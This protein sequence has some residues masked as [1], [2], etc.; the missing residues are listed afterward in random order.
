MKRYLIFRFDDYYPCG[1]MH[2]LVGQ[3]D[4]LDE[5]RENCPIYESYCS[6]EVWDIQTGKD[7]TSEVFK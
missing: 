7:I 6:I 3:Y 4:T 1:G 2:D 5:V